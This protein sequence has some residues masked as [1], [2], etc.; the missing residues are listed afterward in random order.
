MN[1]PDRCDRLTIWCARV[2]ALNR[3]VGRLLAVAMTAMLAIVLTVVVLRYGF[4]FGRV[5]LQEAYLWLHGS[6]LM[7]GI[8]ATLAHDEHVR[9]DLFYR[10]AGPRGRAWIDLLGVI[11]LLL[12]MTATIAWTAFPYVARSWR[13]LEGSRE[14]GGL[15]GLFLFKSILLAF[16]LLTTLQGLS[17]AG[18]SLKVLRER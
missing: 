4:G 9:I 10:S 14:A 16:A 3:A 13:I 8:G 1:R 18:R 11:L 15:P 6:I 12:P 5:W 2:D 7:L 17:L